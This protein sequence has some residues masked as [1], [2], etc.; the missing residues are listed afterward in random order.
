MG[1]GVTMVGTARWA[2]DGTLDR[3]G[4]VVSTP[5]RMA[6]GSWGALGGAGQGAVPGGDER[7]PQASG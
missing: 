3:G 4:G 5:G 7:A 1:Q 6:K 2:Q